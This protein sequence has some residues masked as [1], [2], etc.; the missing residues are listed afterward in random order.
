MSREAERRIRA[1]EG[2]AAGFAAS[3]PSSDEIDGA[4]AR[5]ALVLD[6]EAALSAP[7]SAISAGDYRDMLGSAPPWLAHA[8]LGAEP[9]D[10]F[11]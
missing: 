7:Q 11:L 6:T 8:L 10:L 9:A 5:Y 2:R 4:V 3:K 1:L